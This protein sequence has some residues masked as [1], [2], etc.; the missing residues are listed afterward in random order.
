VNENL[1]KKREGNFRLKCQTH[2]TNEHAGSVGYNLRMSEDRRQNSD[3]LNK[4][5][6]VKCRKSI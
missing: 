6:N 1:Q 4:E 2:A 5:C 3:R